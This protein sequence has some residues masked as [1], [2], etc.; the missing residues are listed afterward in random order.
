[1]IDRTIEND[2]L[3]VQLVR[4]QERAKDAEYESVE[5]KACSQKFQSGQQRYQVAVARVQSEFAALDAWLA[6][7][8]TYFVAR[9]ENRNELTFKLVGALVDAGRLAKVDIYG[10]TK[11]MVH[12]NAFFCSTV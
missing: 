4:A 8:R 11:Q 12:V 1:M 5:A 7:N 6:N 9:L 2:S 3:K 10:E